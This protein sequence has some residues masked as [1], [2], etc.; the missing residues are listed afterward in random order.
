MRTNKE[1]IRRFLSPLSES[2]LPT[3]SD[4]W[5]PGLLAG[6]AKVFLNNVLYDEAA[7][8]RNRST[9]NA[10]TRQAVML[11]S[12][13]REVLRSFLH[14][15]LPRHR[16]H[17]HEQYWS[18]GWQHIHNDSFRIALCIASIVWTE[19]KDHCRYEYATSEAID[20]RWMDGCGKITERSDQNYPKCCGATMGATDAAH[21]ERQRNQIFLFLKFKCLD[22]SLTAFKM[23]GHDHVA[24]YR[25]IPT[26]D[27]YLV[28]FTL[29]NTSCRSLVVR[30]WPGFAGRL[31]T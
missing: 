4:S 19:S 10:W 16:P 28:V 11:G 29:S 1:K 13:C 24:K 23:S 7:A 22:T 3:L 20:G 31:T 6:P 17:H 14:S 18:R 15:P 21:A 12:F 30:I 26:P 8:K 2:H 5:L 27:W 25:N 9:E